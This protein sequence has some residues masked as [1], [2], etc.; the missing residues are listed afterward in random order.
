MTLKDEVLR[1]AV[2]SD[3]KQGPLHFLEPK[4][5]APGKFSKKKRLVEWHN[6]MPLRRTVLIKGKDGANAGT[7]QRKHQHQQLSK[8]HPG[9]DS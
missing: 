2:V 5:K 8:M 7:Q 4:E 9:C 1:F 3:L 6:F